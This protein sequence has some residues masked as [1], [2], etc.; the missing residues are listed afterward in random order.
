MGHFCGFEA[1]GASAVTRRRTQ[2]ERGVI[3]PFDGEV[4]FNT[5]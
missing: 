2:R 5:L 3:R 4:V 1:V